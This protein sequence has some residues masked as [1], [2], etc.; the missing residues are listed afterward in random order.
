[1]AIDTNRL[2]LVLWDIDHTLIESRGVGGQLARSA[3]E[4]VTGVKPAQMA[5]ATGKTESVILA[6]TLRDQGIEP[7]EQHQQRY[8]R[9]LPDQY[10]R[11]ADRLRET[12]RALPGATE[13][14]AALDQVPGVIQTVLTGN[15]REVAAIKL[16][17]FRLAD[18]LD[19]DIG[20]YAEDAT[21]RADLVPVAQHRAADKHGHDF[22][23]DNTI[24]I[25]DTPQ[26][27]AA[28]RQ[29]GATIVAVATGNDSAS[30]LRDA[31]AAT[32]LTDLTDLATVMNAVKTV[33][34]GP[35]T[36]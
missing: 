30:D 27:V 19:L 14:I 22:T 2:C 9:A 16:T 5:D 34:S 10:R 13:A 36:P 1:M 23:R 4:E 33:M 32:V 17:T 28:A 15:Y 26:D 24:I 11:Q 18:L 35:P 3:F 21:D 31:G 29:G 20:A 6:E 8:A 25:G 7:T 12:G